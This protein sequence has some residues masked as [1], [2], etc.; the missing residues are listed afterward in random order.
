MGIFPQHIETLLS[1]Y[2]GV[3]NVIQT[4]G[5]KNIEFHSEKF[6][7]VFW[8]YATC[9]KL[10]LRYDVILDFPAKTIYITEFIC[11]SFNNTVFLALICGIINNSGDEFTKIALTAKGNYRH[12]NTLELYYLCALYGFTPSQNSL[13]DIILSTAENEFEFKGIKDLFHTNNGLQYWLKKGKEW[14]AEFYISGFSENI[15]FLKMELAHKGLSNWL[16][17]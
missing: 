1:E 7:D 16:S 5:I 4:F 9:G 15:Y 8:I 10:K 3:E 13:A 11:D 17:Y 12:A 6:G 2:C 14:R